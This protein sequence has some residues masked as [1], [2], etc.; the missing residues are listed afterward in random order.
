MATY[1]LL[2]VLYTGAHTQ[3]Q[4]PS[5]ELCEREIVHQMTSP[6]YKHIKILEC[7]KV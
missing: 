1:I 7:N 4:Y 3:I 2:M 5:I 6:E